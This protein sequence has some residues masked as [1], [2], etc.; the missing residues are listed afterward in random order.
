M[1]KED[2][3]YLKQE[4]L[5]SEIINQGYDQISFINYISSLKEDGANIDN[6]T[7]T[8]LTTIVSEF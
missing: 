3:K 8:E 4:Y 5:R 2:K 6:W 7:F 1:K